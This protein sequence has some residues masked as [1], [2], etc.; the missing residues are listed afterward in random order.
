MGDSDASTCKDSSDELQPCHM[1]SKRTT[2][3]EMVE[4]VRSEQELFRTIQ[5]EMALDVTTSDRFLAHFRTRR[6]KG[7][8][9]SPPRRHPQPRNV[10]AN[11]QKNMTVVTK[12]DKQNE[13]FDSCEISSVSEWYRESRFW[14]VKGPSGQKGIPKIYVFLS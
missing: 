4:M 6:A 1:F 2:K 5:N 7:L 11:A 13:S 9:P 3:R 14:W 10:T 8:A 12:S